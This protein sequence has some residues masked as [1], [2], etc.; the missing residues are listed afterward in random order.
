MEVTLEGILIED[1][2]VQPENAAPEMVFKL[3]G[4][5]TVVR[6]EHP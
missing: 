2:L 1:K 6:L 5:L 4:I 3:E